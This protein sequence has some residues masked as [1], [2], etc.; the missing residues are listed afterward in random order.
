MKINGTTAADAAVFT[1]A[2]MQLPQ[3]GMLQ[4]LPAMQQ[5]LQQQQQAMMQ[6]MSQQQQGM[7]QGMQGMQGMMAQQGMEL[8]AQQGM[9]LGGL[10]P[11][12]LLGQPQTMAVFRGGMGRPPPRAASDRFASMRWKLPVYQWRGALLEAMEKS[13]VVV[14][15]GETGCGKT[16]QVPHYVL[17]AACEMGRPCNVV[18]TQP[19][20]IS[21]IGVASRVADER[22]EA[23]GRTVGF[24]IRH[25]SCASRETMLMFC[26]T[27][28][29]LRRLEGDPTLRQVSHVFVDE[30]HERGLE[31]DFLLLAL[32]DMLPSRPDLK[33]ILMSATMDADRFSAYFGGAPIFQV[34]GRTFPVKTLYLED[35]LKM[36]GHRV[37]PRAEWSKTGGGWRKSSNKLSTLARSGSPTSEGEGSDDLRPLVDKADWELQERE[38]AIRYG[39]NYGAQVARLQIR[40]YVFVQC[41]CMHADNHAGIHILQH[42]SAL[43]AILFAHQVMRSRTTILCNVNIYCFSGQFRIY[44]PMCLYTRTLTYT[45]SYRRMHSCLCIISQ[46]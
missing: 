25:E 23:C 34:P 27:G 28:T 2:A 46:T 39:R 9:E 36:T 30:V 18:C 8:M 42:I 22:G 7:L 45:H 10:P 12:G 11:D 33:V 13:Q 37:D 31:S 4:G 35:A 21:A 44:M 40:I 32:K 41:A 19:R 6:A 29:L 24:S 17:E 5:Q 16:T 20:R 1:P 15:Q 14:I 3:G 43:H 38:L 26:T